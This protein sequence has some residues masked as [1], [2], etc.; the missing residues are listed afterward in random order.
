MAGSI[1]LIGD[2]GMVAYHERDDQVAYDLLE[3]S[4][5]LS[6]QHGLKDR[7]AEALNRLGDLARLAGDGKGARKRYEESLTIWRE[8]HGNPGIASALHKLG[9]V[10][11]VYGDLVVAH[12]RFTES[13]TLQRDSGNRQGV[14]E[15]LAGLA[16]VSLDAGELELAARLL[17]ASAAAL[18]AIGAPLAPAD[19]VVVAA[20]IASGR[21]RLGE[22]AWEVAW[23]EGQTVPLA[24]L[25]EEALASSPPATSPRSG[26]SSQTAL[27]S[28]REQEVAALVARGLTNRVIAEN[29]TIGERTVETHVSHI[30]AKL[31]FTSRA[32]IVAWA[33]QQ[34][35]TTD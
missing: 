13:L 15:C 16:G 4:L 22:A 30:L 23:S 18:E 9:Q 26:N 24:Q 10:S 20:D 8:L 27:L 19:Q 7:V 35:P 33:N 28:R 34:K 21:L 3:E 25:V 14:A 1:T 17:G 11:R 2:L 12:E 31:D 5:R 32:Q 6:R 29:L